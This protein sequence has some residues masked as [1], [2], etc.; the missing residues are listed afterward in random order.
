MRVRVVDPSGL[1]VLHDATV[2]AP[3]H[4]GTPGAIRDRMKPLAR[5]GRIFFIDGADPIDMRVD[6]LI[7]ESISPELAWLFEQDGGAF[8]LHVPSGSLRLTGVEAWAAGRGR[9]PDTFAVPP[10]AYALVVHRRTT[11]DPATYHGALARHVGAA[12]L[13][14]HTRVNRL[15]LLGCLPLALTALALL[16]RRW[17]VALVL[18]GIA[19]LASAPWALLSRSRRYREAERRYEAYH[20]ELP[21]FILELRPV[22][23]TASLVGGYVTAG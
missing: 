10:G 9:E 22:E 2:P 18:A 4:D 14:F 7:G 21:A 8:L 6:L 19:L 20:A 5:E 15:A 16:A 3:S 23:S 11:P 13:A 1:A 12:D 17:R